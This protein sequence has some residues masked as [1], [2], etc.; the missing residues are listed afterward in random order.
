MTTI[1]LAHAA[2]NRPTANRSTLDGST[3][4]L[5]AAPVRS[6]APADVRRSRV[7]TRLTRRGRAVL[8][9]L[10]V[11]PLLMGGGALLASGGAMAG[12]RSSGASFH[13]L[14]VQ[15]GESLWSIAQRVAPRDDPRDVVLAFVDLNGL[16]SSMVQ[17]GERL[18][19]PRE[20]DGSSR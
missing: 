1:A 14:T 6:Q 2:R 7:R 3:S 5:D 4:H 11:L 15:S 8:S 12:I 16:S 17:A 18:A 19:I 10:I 20:F 13:H 9:A